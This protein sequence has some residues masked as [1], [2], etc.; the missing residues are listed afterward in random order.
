MQQDTSAS[1]NINTRLCHYIPG[2]HTSLA[3]LLV[4]PPHHGMKV[5]DFFVEVFNPYCNVMLLSNSNDATASTDGQ[6]NGFHASLD[7]SESSSASNTLGRGNIHISESADESTH[8]YKGMIITVRV[9]EPDKC[10]KAALLQEHIESIDASTIMLKVNKND[11]KEGVKICI[12]NLNDSNPLVYSTILCDDQTI[13]ESLQKDILQL[14]HEFQ[15]ATVTVGD[16]DANSH[17]LLAVKGPEFGLVVFKTVEEN[18]NTHTAGLKVFVNDINEDHSNHLFGQLVSAKLVNLSNKLLVQLSDFV[19]D[20]KSLSITD[21][22][23]T[24]KLLKNSPT[25][26]SEMLR[27]AR[28]VNSANPNKFK[29]GVG[30]EIVPTIC[31]DHASKVIDFFVEGLDAKIVQKYS[32]R[33]P[34]FDEEQIFHVSLEIGAGTAMSGLVTVFSSLGSKDPSP[35]DI[36]IYVEDLNKA[37]E[38]AKAFSPDVKVKYDVMDM[39]WGEKIVGLTYDV[40]N[41]T[42]SQFTSNFTGGFVDHPYATYCK[43]QK[44][45]LKQLHPFIPRGFGRITSMVDVDCSIKAYTN[46][47]NDTAFDGKGKMI[48]DFPH[49]N[50]PD[51]YH[52]AILGSPSE[53]SALVIRQRMQPKEGEETKFLPSTLDIY[54]KD[55]EESLEKVKS[56]CNASESMKYEIIENV[57]DWGYGLRNFKIKDPSGNMLFYSTTTHRVNFSMLGPHADKVIYGIYDESDDQVNEKKRVERDEEKD[58]DGVQK[59]AKSA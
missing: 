48:I 22:A 6:G 45:E 36:T 19:G 4:V 53:E 54:V 20:K 16:G 57:K 40:V 14:N 33:L 17:S 47:I 42:L 9:P 18:K 49:P 25:Y 5:V 13:C 21:D 30:N 31:S 50:N 27:Y 34:G 41:L 58:D 8:T 44:A 35:A 59:K 37:L 32:E 43:S 39:E 10:L 11:D 15:A 46:F 29:P 56:I 38:K 12:C 51:D 24:S 26:I 7:F 3:P 55:S 28:I 2:F 1:S 23:M 52:F